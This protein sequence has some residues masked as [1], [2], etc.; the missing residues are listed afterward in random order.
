MKKWLEAAGRAMVLAFVSSAAI[1][2]PGIFE[3]PNLA[4]ARGLG[5]VALG[6]G[7]TGAL[8]ALKEALPAFSWRTIL[9]S[10]PAAWTSRFDIF[11]FTAAGALIVAWTDV[12]NQ[13][14]DLS[15]WPGLFVAGASGAIAAGL[16][17]VIGAGTK[18]ETGLGLGPDKGLG[19]EPASAAPPA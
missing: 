19:G 10:V 7:I 15:T 16:R 12:I 5:V 18:G 9:S 1:Y 17:A 13:A 6:A 14:P 8:G 2:L 11:T 3:A 4:D